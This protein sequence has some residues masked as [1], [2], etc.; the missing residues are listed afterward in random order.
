MEVD[1]GSWHLEKKVPI[2]IIAALLVQTVVITTW[3]TQKF[4]GLD[5][6]VANIEKSD[7]GQQS[8]ESRLVVLEQ[9]FSYIRDD[10]QEIKDIL[11]RSIPP[12]KQ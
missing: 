10:L 8:H 12:I 3:I 1:E 11:R 6:R 9:K 2:T 5:N 4:D 7:D